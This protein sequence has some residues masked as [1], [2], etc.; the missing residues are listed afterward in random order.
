MR[1]LMTTSLA[2]LALGAA[3]TRGQEN[4]LTYHEASG[5]GWANVFDGGP[6]VTAFGHTSGPTDPTMSFTARDRTQPGSMGASA[7]AVGDS[8][9]VPLGEDVMMVWVQL[10]AE[11]IPSF[12]PGGD[13][14]GGAAEGELFSI[15]EFV[16]PADEI[17]WDYRLRIDDT[18]GFE[19]GTNVLFE[20]VT[21][22]QILLDLSEDTPQVQTTLSAN[23]GD[24]MRITSIMSG[25][26][27]TQGGSVR[28]YEAGLRMFFTVPE[29]CTLLLLVGAVAATR[30][31]RRA[32]G[33]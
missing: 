3:G 19:G 14:P 33:W 10:R 29:P 28:E 5:E 12:F 4:W 11:Y 22:S 6:P 24:L 20:N 17:L 32:Q 15:I 27:E 13:N 1:S 18:L 8:S 23:T 26:G 31:T 9:M 30:K 25:S 21:Q 2:L 16:M 7:R